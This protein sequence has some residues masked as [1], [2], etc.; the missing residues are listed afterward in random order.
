LLVNAEA[1]VGGGSVVF[2][3]EVGG[4]GLTDALRGGRFVVDRAELTADE[5]ARF[6]G[7]SAARASIAMF[8]SR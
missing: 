5:V 6:F 1:R 3:G 4:A 2:G 7:F 8:V